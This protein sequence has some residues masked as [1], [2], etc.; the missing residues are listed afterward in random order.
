MSAV[1]PSERMSDA[2]SGALSKRLF[3]VNCG[4]RMGLECLDSMESFFF[5]F[6]VWVLQALQ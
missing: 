4:S 2:V 1:E 5:L 6:K 3:V